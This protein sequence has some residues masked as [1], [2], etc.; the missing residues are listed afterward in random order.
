MKKLATLSTNCIK[1]FIA[2]LAIAIAGYCNLLSESKWLGSVL[3]SF[4]LIYVCKYR[5]N[6][7]TGMAGYITTTK[8]PSF[9]VSIVVNLVAAFATGMLLSYNPSAVENANALLGVK[10]ETDI[11]SVLIS[12]V[13]C[14][15]LIFLSVDY[16]KRFSSIIG[17]IFAI[18]IFVLCGFD[19]AVADAFYIGIAGTIN[20]NLVLFILTVVVGNIIGSTLM[21]HLLYL[22]KEN[23]NENK[24][25]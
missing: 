24:N 20:K 19:H 23:V 8:I 18:P 3:F 4:G 9:I 10:L 11:L 13:M 7:F 25:V 1:S 12:S 6:L 2:A 14:G 22:F 15:V 21:R 16:Y 17:I 5:M